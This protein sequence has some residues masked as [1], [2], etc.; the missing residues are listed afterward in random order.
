M[1][2][3]AQKKEKKMRI[4]AAKANLALFPGEPAPQGWVWPS[5][6]KCDKT[7]RKFRVW[8]QCTDAALQRYPGLL[9]LLTHSPGAGQSHS[10]PARPE[11][12][13]LQVNKVCHLSRDRAVTDALLRVPERACTGQLWTKHSVVQTRPSVAQQGN[14]PPL[15]SPASVTFASQLSLVSHAQPLSQV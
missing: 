9:Q 13:V 8:L 15:L 2:G 14:P 4:S 12:I 11:L 10:S 1:P 6:C 3:R 7:D 5:V